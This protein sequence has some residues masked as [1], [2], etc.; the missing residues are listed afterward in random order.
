M[1]LWA[2][3]THVD[4]LLD[5]LRPYR[6]LEDIPAFKVFDRMISPR[7]RVIVADLLDA[8]AQGPAQ[9][10]EHDARRPG[11]HFRITE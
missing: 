3:D 10:Q 8:V 7:Q 1:A 5:A 2:E 9:L 11:Q 4:A 6:Q